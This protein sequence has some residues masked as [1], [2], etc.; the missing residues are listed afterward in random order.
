MYLAL[1]GDGQES[2]EFF[3]AQASSLPMLH[4]FHFGP[5]TE[6]LK[7][8]NRSLRQGL[9]GIP[10]QHVR[11]ILFLMLPTAKLSCRGQ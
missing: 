4:T 6:L 5:N 8:A 11:D 1:N 7:P 9:V 10:E 3:A 2:E